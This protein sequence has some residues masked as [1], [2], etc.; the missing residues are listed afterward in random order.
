MWTKLSSSWPGCR[1]TLG[2]A[3]K[4][5]HRTTPSTKDAKLMACADPVVDETLASL[6]A[7]HRS[8]SSS[9]SRSTSPLA[10]LLTSAPPASISG[11]VS[12]AV[13]LRSMTQ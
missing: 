13:R 10:T 8:T 12:H 5:L 4:K 11:I 9:P 6:L 2:F 7:K 3:L 1:F